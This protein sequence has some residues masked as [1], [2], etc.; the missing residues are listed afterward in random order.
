MPGI[1]FLYMAVYGSPK[2]VRHSRGGGIFLQKC[3]ESL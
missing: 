3:K 2:G 1:I